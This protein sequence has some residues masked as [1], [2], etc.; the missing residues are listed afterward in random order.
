MTIDFTPDLDFYKVEAV[1]DKVL[2][3]NN[4]EDLLHFSKIYRYWDVIIGGPLATKTIPQKLEYRTLT[5]LV[6]DAAYAH[7][8]RFFEGRILD[9]IS[10]PEICGENIVRKV[11]YH[12]GPIRKRE[13]QYTA[14]VQEQKKVNSLIPAKVHQAQWV[15]RQI[16]D[17]RLKKRFSRLMAKVTSKKAKLHE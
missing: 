6:E 11:R 10:S 15:A 16:S 17:E 7:H 9:L 1:V 2:V 14:D 4:R 3:E 5:I 13:S 12:V 8:L